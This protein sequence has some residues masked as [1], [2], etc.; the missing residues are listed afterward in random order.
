M[1]ASIFKTNTLCH[2]KVLFFCNFRFH[3]LRKRKY[4]RTTKTHYKNEV[5]RIIRVVI[6]KPFHL[7]ITSELYINFSWQRKFAPEGVKQ[8]K[9]DFMQDQCNMGKR[10]NLTPL[11]QKV[12]EFLSA[13]LT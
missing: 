6:K 1:V 13:K 5:Y 4:I 8:G 2:L 3:I 9:E 12:G 7:K 11:E 10:L